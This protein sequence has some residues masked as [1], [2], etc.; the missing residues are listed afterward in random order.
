[1]GELTGD[2]FLNMLAAEIPRQNRRP[3]RL[4]E[5]GQESDGVGVRLN[6]ARLLFS[7]AT[8]RRKL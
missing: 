2:E 1:V 7:P 6:R 5:H 8:I 4:V 3:G